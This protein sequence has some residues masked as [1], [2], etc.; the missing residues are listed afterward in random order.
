MH[1]RPRREILRKQYPASVLLPLPFCFFIA[2]VLPLSLAR[3]DKRF[4]FLEVAF[5][6]VGLFASPVSL[7]VLYLRGPGSQSVL[8]PLASA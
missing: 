2:S 7:E 1:E 3:L 4:G 8:R 5:E 6:P